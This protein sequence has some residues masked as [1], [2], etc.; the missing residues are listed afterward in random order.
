MLSIDF[1]TSVKCEGLPSLSN[2]R[3]C[4]LKSCMNFKLPYGTQAGSFLVD[5]NTTPDISCISISNGEPA[6]VSR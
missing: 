1:G 6:V 2:N 3:N 4:P 5:V